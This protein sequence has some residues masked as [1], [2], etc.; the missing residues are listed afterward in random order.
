MSLSATALSESER[1]QL[2]RAFEST[3]PFFKLLSTLR[4]RRVGLG[5]RC[6]TG[7]PE[8]LEWSSGRTV[9]QAKGPLAFTLGQ[10]RPGGALRA[11][12]RGA[13]R[14]A[15]CGPNGIALADIP[16]HGNLFSLLSWAGRT[17]PG[18]DAN[19]SIDLFVVNDRGTHV[20]RPGEDRSGP[21][22][23]RSPEDYAKVLDL[24]PVGPR[25]G[26]RPPP[27]HRLARRPG[28]HPLGRHDEPGAVQREPAREHL[29]DPGRRRR[30]RVVQPAVLLL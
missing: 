25:A 7:E 29:A 23:I 27:G 24:V 11:G 18:G 6:E 21:I 15:A 22:E 26:L 1:D 12:R 19:A 14:R 17:V 28:G 4:T 20:Y 8:V 9:K 30:A 10:T 13:I 3:P 2:A 16:L 5:Y